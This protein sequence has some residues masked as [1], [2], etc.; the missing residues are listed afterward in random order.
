[1]LFHSVSSPAG[2]LS[3]TIVA[4]SPAA[5]GEV[6]SAIAGLSGPTAA[7]PK[8]SRPRPSVA[9]A[10]RVIMGRAPQLEQIL[11]WIVGFPRLSLKHEQCAVKTAGGRAVA[12]DFRDQ[13]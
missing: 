5:V 4:L 7:H 6:S 8:N 10:L 12:A 11:A 1:M 9:S 3:T 13:A 2:D